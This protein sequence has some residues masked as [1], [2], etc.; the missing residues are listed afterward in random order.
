M[1]A[2]EIAAWVFQ[3]CVTIACLVGVAC[4]MF[5]IGFLLWVILRVLG[6]A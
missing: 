6:L 1:N 2:V 5:V 3:I 4:I